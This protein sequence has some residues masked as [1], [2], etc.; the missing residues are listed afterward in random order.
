MVPTSS[1]LD[2]FIVVKC[3]QMYFF[4]IFIM[5]SPITITLIE[6]DM[7]VLKL[8]NFIEF[9]FFTTFY[10]ITYGWGRELLVSLFPV[11][12]VDD[13]WLYIQMRE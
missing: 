4:L 5:S 12:E 13:I 1:L 9:S 2:T 7:K 6:I 11:F 8:I 3:L 10:F